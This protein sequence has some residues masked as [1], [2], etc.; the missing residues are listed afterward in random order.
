MKIRTTFGTYE[1]AYLS[2]SRYEADDSLF[3]SAWCFG[4]GPI[5]TLTVCLHDRDLGADE[6]YVDVNNFP[7]VLELI[8]DLG[9]GS[10]TGKVRQSGYVTYPVVKF[11]MKKLGG[12]VYPAAV[13]TVCELKE[14][15]TGCI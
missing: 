12:C 3:V 15:K 8:A 7:E 4:K 13:R 5:A 9:I 10:P 11:D 2:V 6:S 1:N 14:E